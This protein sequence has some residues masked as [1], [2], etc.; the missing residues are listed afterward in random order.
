[1]WFLIE[2][3]KY[4][5]LEF[6][7]RR[8]ISLSPGDWWRCPNL[9]KRSR[10]KLSESLLYF[11]NVYFWSW[12]ITHYNETLWL[13]KRRQN[14]VNFKLNNKINIIEKI[15]YLGK[16]YLEGAASRIYISSIECFFCSCRRFQT[17][18]CE[19]FG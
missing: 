3:E 7:R 8:K 4:E 17:I 10:L 9:N 2:N 18:K 13:I 16:L 11:F 15:T 14:L 1:M 19:G 6:I 12:L 5:K